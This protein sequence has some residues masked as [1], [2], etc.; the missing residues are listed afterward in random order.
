MHQRLTKK[1]P[2]QTIAYEIDMF[3]HCGRT[4]GRKKAGFEKTTAHE[5]RAEYYLG[6]EGFLLHLRNLLAFLTNRR[7]EST[8]LGI[9]RPE[10]WAERPVEKREYS[11][12]M[13]SARTL[14]RQYGAKHS[15]CYDQ[16]S[17]FLQHCTTHRHEQDR[18]WDVEQI[19]ADLDPV[20][21]EFEKRFIPNM[22]QDSALSVPLLRTVNN[23]TASMRTLSSTI[24]TG[25]FEK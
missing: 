20:L 10:D 18:D 7:S 6:F 11:D 13:K 12:L 21:Q 19:S 14:D 15:T 3:R 1:T 22:V 23:S 4:L 9:N 17:K 5:E 2:L 16:I 8:D 25:P 24:L